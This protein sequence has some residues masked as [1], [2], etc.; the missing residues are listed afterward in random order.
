MRIFEPAW[1]F[2]CPFEEVS[3]TGS[4]STRVLGPFSFSGEHVATIAH[5]LSEL[6]RL[7]TNIRDN[8]PFK[9]GNET[10]RGEKAVLGEVRLST[11]LTEVYIPC[12][13]T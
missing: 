4:V 1:L 9:K 13:S 8:L 6:I 10:T 3:E 2:V 7:W 5:K 11:T 12:E